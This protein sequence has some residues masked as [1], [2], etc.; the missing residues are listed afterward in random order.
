MVR[1][2]GGKDKN[3]VL[4]M[5]SSLSFRQ[6]KSLAHAPVVELALLLLLRGPGLEIRSDDEQLC[7]LCCSHVED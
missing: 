5:I 7:M 1:F 6:E 3:R 4:M 2:L